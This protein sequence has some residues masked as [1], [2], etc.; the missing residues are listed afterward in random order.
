MGEAA[1]KVS[2]VPD[3]IREN[4]GEAASI[5]VAGIVL[6]LQRSNL[7]RGRIGCRSHNHC[8]T[9]EIAPSTQYLAIIASV[10][11][12]TMGGLAAVPVIAAAPPVHRYTSRRWATRMTTIVFD[13][14]SIS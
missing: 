14:S 9:C 11:S 10:S 4:P 12:S 1:V 7:I 8:L 6:G 2:K 5:G 13:L 3:F